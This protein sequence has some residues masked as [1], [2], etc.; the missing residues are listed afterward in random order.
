MPKSLVLGN[1]KILVGYDNHGQVNDFYY[2][3]V[4]HDNHMTEESVNRVG[5][6]VDGKMSWF[7]SGEW[8]IEICYHDESLTSSII[9]KN[10]DIQIEIEFQDCVYNEENIFLRRVKVK[11]LANTQRTVKIFFN[12]QF[13]MY[14]IRK[15][16][17]VYYDPNN[18]TIVHYKG[19]RVAII[20]GKIGDRN[21]D[22][23]TV[24][25][26]E[27]EGKE[28]TWRDAE[29]GILAENPIE[30]G[31]VDSTIGFEEAVD[32][33]KSFEFSTWV[34]FA[35]TFEEARRLNQVVIKKTS[36]HIME[37]T[38][39]F[40]KAWVNKTDFSFYG[41]DE[42]VI[43]LFKKSLLVMRTHVDNEGGIIA[44]G[45]SDLL[46]YGRDNYSYVWHRDAAF[47]AMSLDKAGYHEVVRRFFQFSRDVI[48]EEGYFYHKYK[49]DKA[50]GSSW[51]PW[52]LDGKKQLPIQEDETALV[53]Y[54]L[55][56]HYTYTKDIEFIEVLYNPLIKKAANFM[57]GFRNDKSLPNPTYDLWE[58]KS[59]IHTFTV[60]TVHGALIAA[61]NFARV[62][63][64]EI[65]TEL[66]SKGAEEIKEAAMKYL[67]NEDN[68][69]FHKY[70]E[71]DGDK[72]LHDKTID[73]SSFFW[74]I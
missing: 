29:D 3:Y 58:M 24:G 57:L 30:H 50:L 22:Q 60:A 69:Y 48:S 21:F 66:F 9:A 17:T 16:D 43:D 36:G 47:V 49:P 65:D 11:N 34:V 28:G 68:G 13:R 25:L 5:V 26:S 52:I 6:W 44:S 12:H 40:W 27:I 61:A 20:A 62:L 38:H 33:E 8:D 19:R 74:C 23:W 1:G 15:G 32:A 59:G 71:F 10:A 51:H 53:I 14:R 56:E 46:Q 64:K 70:V 73:A 54:A 67:Y 31:T 4:G 7:S 55:W 63:G 18:R 45:D 37:S 42:P 39:D 72:I 35:K 41:L 2:D